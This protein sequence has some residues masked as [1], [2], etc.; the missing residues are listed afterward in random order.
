MTGIA[1]FVVNSAILL[2]EDKITLM[3]QIETNLKQSFID[4]FH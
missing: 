3:K 4:M 1:E 2:F